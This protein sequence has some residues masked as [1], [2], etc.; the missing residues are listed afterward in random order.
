MSEVV[1][2]AARIGDA[3]ALESI[4]RECF[5]DPWSLDSLLSSL[6]SPLYYARVAADGG[7]IEAYLIASLVLGEGEL[8]RIAVRPGNRARGI[9]RAL[10]E[11]MLKENP[12]ITPWRLDVR[13][14]NY[15]AR[16]L[17]E[18][19]GFKPVIRRRD[20][21]EK[22]REDGIMMILEG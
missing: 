2:R 19:I 9:G 15:A 11:A 16:K 20:Y 8:L 10:V 1:I 13:E 18:A 5:S 4:E 12:G 22:P 7:R 3:A 21:Y 14:S 6:A 17:Y